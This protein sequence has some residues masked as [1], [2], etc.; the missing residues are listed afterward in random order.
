M[1]RAIECIICNNLLSHSLPTNLLPN[2][3]ASSLPNKNEDIC[4]LT[5]FLTAFGQ[6]MRLMG[7]RIYPQRQHL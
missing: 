2:S 6:S 4:G 7:M 5:L 3:P 1:I